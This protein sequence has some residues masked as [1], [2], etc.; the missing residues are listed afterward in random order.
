MTNQLILGDC[1][2]KMR[3]FPEASVDAVITDPPYGLEFMGKDWDSF[4]TKGQGGGWQIAGKPSMEKFKGRNDIFSNPTPAFRGHTLSEWR[5]F[6]DFSQKWAVEALRVLKPG[7]FLFSFGGTR[8]YHRMACGIEDA[9]FKIRDT[10]AW[11]YLQGFPKA[12]DLAGLISKREGAG[13][14]GNTFPL[15]PEYQ[16]Y[17][18][19]ENGKKW[20]GWKTPALKPAFEP[21]VVAQKPVEGSITENVMKHGVGG[22]NIEEC[23]IPMEE[24]EEVPRGNIPYEMKADNNFGGGHDGRKGDMTLTS[25]SGRYPSN[26]LMTEPVF[27]ELGGGFSKFFIIPKAGTTEKSEGI[28][29][30]NERE[31]R[32]NNGGEWQN[33]KTKYK[34][35]HPT[36]KPVLLMEHLIKLTTK[37]GSVVLDPFMGSGTTGVAAY[38]LGRSFI[39]IEK[40]PDY[41]KIAEARIGEAN[42]QQHLEI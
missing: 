41:M 28:G 37:R 25:M 15:K 26:I 10:L 5:A 36:V 19:T 35:N 22:F 3:E 33:L 18:L 1:I 12:Q 40:E 23:R 29:W 38:Q 21:I 7:G 8:T 6:Q 16:E 30:E 24:G 2:E 27:E 13:S 39:G 31:C 42:K 34:N 32:W 14:E 4:K 17:V 11:C 9:G 20:A